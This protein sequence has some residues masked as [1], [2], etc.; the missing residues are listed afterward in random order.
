MSDWAA[1]LPDVSVVRGGLRF[2]KFMLSANGLPVALKDTHGL[3]LRLA[4]PFGYE[5]KFECHHLD[6]HEQ[7]GLLTVRVKG[8]L[9]GG[10][11]AHTMELLHVESRH[12]ASGAVA[13]VMLATP[14]ERGTVKGRR[15]TGLATFQLQLFRPQTV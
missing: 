11:V 14:A 6:V 4:A 9:R 3:M 15:R 12:D 7:D 5:G 13:T 10:L 2:P 8:G 1:Y